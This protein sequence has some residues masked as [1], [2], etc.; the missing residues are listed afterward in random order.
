MPP[1]INVAAANAQEAEALLAQR[2]A[3]FTP[4]VVCGT[5][6]PWVLNGTS[7]VA[8][9][10]VKLGVVY[11]PGEHCFSSNM[12][13]SLVLTAFAERRIEN[14]VVNNLID[15]SI[16]NPGTVTVRGLG[17]GLPVLTVNSADLAIARRSLAL[18]ARTQ[19]QRRYFVGSEIRTGGGPTISSDRIFGQNLTGRD[20]LIFLV[21]QIGTNGLYSITGTQINCP[22]ST[23]TIGCQGGVVVDSPGQTSTTIFHFITTL[24]ITTSVER[25]IT[26]G[27]TFYDAPLTQLP[28]GAIHAAA[29]SAGFDTADRFLTRLERSDFWPRSG[30]A[31]ACL[32]RGMDR[33]HPLQCEK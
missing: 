1:V 31:R 27:T 14:T 25:T 32:G 10:G 3:G 5:T 30:Q 15:N 2:N 8:A 20:T 9:P 28:I 33:A 7:V 26:G 13:N 18:T 11:N 29:Q 19:S 12:A 4:G 24:Y 22:S 17:S 21:D 23:S 16:G 6:L